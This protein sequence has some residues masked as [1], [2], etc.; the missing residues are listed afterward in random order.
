MPSPYM[1]SKYASL[2][3]GAHLILDDLGTRAVADDLRAVLDGFGAADIDTDGRVELQR[4]A[5]SGRFGVAVHD[6]DLHTQL[7]DEDDDA[8][9]LGDIA[10]ELPQRLRHETRLQTD[11]RIA[12]FALNFRAR[13]QCRDRVDDDDVHCAGAHQRVCDLQRLLAGIRLGDE[14][15]SRYR[16]RCL[17]A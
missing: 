4:V 17:A 1:I 10:R 3:G 13:R 15:A 14:H 2:K 7:V 9:G 5:A 12:H 16:R 8:V 6:A 11:E